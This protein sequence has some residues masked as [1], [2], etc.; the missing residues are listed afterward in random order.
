M[1]IYDVSHERR[2]YTTHQITDG[3]ANTWITYVCEYGPNHLNPPV[4]NSFEIKKISQISFKPLFV[5]NKTLE[6]D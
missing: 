4:V 2:E 3:L 5:V 1:Y 6:V